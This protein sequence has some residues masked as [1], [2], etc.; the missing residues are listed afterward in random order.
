MWH[1]FKSIVKTSQ[2]ELL[3]SLNGGEKPLQTR[4]VS[5]SHLKNERQMLWI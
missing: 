3:S 4:Y 2:S 1:E 5:L